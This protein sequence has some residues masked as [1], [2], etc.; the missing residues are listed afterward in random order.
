[1]RLKEESL[2]NREK[3]IKEIDFTDHRRPGYPV[4]HE[5]PR[6]D[7]PT[8]GTRTRQPPQPLSGWKY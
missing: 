2:M 5:H 7:N 4:P 8:G 3:P 6:D 1:M